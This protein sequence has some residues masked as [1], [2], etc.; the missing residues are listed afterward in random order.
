MCMMQLQPP[1]L[2]WLLGMPHVASLFIMCKSPDS[3]SC[4]RLPGPPPKCGDLTPQSSVD[5]CCSSK[6]GFK[7]DAT[8]PCQTAGTDGWW[9]CCQDR[10][11]NGTEDATCEYLLYLRFCKDAFSVTHSAWHGPAS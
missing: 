4:P 1:A 5:A 8:C 10:K 11:T 9:Q 3:Q 7:N 6:G 2:A